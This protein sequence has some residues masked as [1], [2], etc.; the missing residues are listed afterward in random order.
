MSIPSAASSPSR[1]SRPF[2]L[3]RR[4]TPPLADIA[5]WSDT[6]HMGPGDGEYDNSPLP[7]NLV[8]PDDAS[9]LEADRLAWL[10]E[11]RSLR[12]R[13]RLRRLVFTRQWEHFGMSGPIVVGCLLLT[14]LVGTLAVVFVPR[15]AWP[16]PAP[17]PLTS[18]AV[19]RLT[20]GG[21]VLGRRLPT[22]TLD[23]DVRPVTATDLRPAVIV[24]T[25]PDCGCSD[26]LRAVYRQ[27]RQFRLTVWLI[28][29]RHP[30]EHDDAASRD[31]KSVV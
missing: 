8:V 19:A 15:P 24:L 10:A 28:D 13:R 12:R 20:T 9:S 23:G 1:R 21:G 7:A 27:A 29:T 6:R 31:R 11:Q 18:A 16:E 2:G 3:F 22:I 26:V 25:S 5:P 14:A 17:A 4:L 30:G